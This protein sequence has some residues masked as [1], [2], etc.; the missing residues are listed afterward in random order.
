MNNENDKRFDDL[1]RNKLENPVDKSGF[2]EEDWDSL[3]Q[4]LDK[5]TKRRGIVYL[6]PILS[7]VAALLL[8]FLGWWAFR[9]Q[10]SGHNQ[11]TKSQAVTVRTPADSGSKHAVNGQSPVHT[12]AVKSGETYAVNPVKG[13]KKV[14]G[15]KPGI[16]LAGTTQGDAAAPDKKKF[17]KRGWVNQP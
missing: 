17:R 10:I 2:R 16:N 9:P 3:E 13:N 7:S 11:P 4:M 14:S 15:N 1:F 6:L 12:Q 5:H 8:L